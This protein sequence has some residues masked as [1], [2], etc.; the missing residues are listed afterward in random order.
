M[1]INGRAITMEEFNRLQASPPLHLKTRDDLIDSLV[2]RELLIQEAQKEGID[3]E[4]AFRQSIQNFYEQSLIKL[5]LDRKFESVKVSVSD[6]ELDSYLSFLGRK[7][8]LTVFTAKT[9]K[10]AREGNYRDVR[11]REVNFDSLSSY[12][13]ERVARLKEGQRTKPIG[14]GG[15]FVVARLDKLEGSPPATPSK[16]E[17]EDVRRMLA[18][19]KTE[20]SISKWVDGLRQKA[21][22]KI[23]LHRKD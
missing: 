14:E 20:K 12:M 3:K 8:R 9:M 10:D 7:I 15:K 11:T 6:G 18:E 13:R 19:E 16:E 4:E 1:V 17:R 21:S 5:L 22:V 23:M 2:T